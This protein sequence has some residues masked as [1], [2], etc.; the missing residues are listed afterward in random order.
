MRTIWLY[1]KS[2]GVGGQ[3]KASCGRCAKS[4]FISEFVSFVA[5]M[6]CLNRPKLR[7]QEVKENAK[8]K[9]KGNFA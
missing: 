6:N 8:S 5:E 2:T 4:L 9:K 3:G 1:Q 7:L